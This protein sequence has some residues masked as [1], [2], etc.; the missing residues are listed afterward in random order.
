MLANPVVHSQDDI[1]RVKHIGYVTI[2]G[3]VLGFVS[4]H[5]RLPEH[6]LLLEAHLEFWSR[7]SDVFTSGKYRLDQSKALR[8]ENLWVVNRNQPKQAT[9]PLPCFKIVR[10]IDLLCD[11]ISYISSQAGR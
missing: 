8:A 6:G 1:F 4:V 7:F 3:I 11:D 10:S 2:P 9:I 5:H